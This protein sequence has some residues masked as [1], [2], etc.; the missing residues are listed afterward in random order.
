MILIEQETAMEMDS[1]EPGAGSMASIQDLLNDDIEIAK[2]ETER[3]RRENSHLQ[4]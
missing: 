2:S 1:I 4:K 3:V